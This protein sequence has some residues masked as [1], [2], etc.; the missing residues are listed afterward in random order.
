[1]IY[2]AQLTAF[3]ATLYVILMSLCRVYIKILQHT[4]M[5]IHYKLNMRG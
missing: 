2:Q 3:L 1:M 4:A 5:T